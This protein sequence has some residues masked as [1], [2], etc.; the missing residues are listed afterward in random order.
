MCDCKDLSDEEAQ[1]FATEFD[2]VQALRGGGRLAQHL[3]L[4]HEM[5]T[6]AP[7]AL[8]E[9]MLSLMPNIEDDETQLAVEELMSRVCPG[10]EL[11][12]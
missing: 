6:L 7:E 5:S 9:R 11:I 4:L 2:L 12:P 3:T 1:A 10:W 8:C